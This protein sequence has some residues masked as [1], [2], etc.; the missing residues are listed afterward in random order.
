MFK[1]SSK[2]RWL[3]RRL[4]LWNGLPGC[5]QQQWTRWWH[6]GVE[7]TEYRVCKTFVFPNPGKL[8]FFSSWTIAAS[9]REPIFCWTIST[10]MRPIAKACIMSPLSFIE[11]IRRRLL[12]ISVISKLSKRRLSS[13]ALLSPNTMSPIGL[14]T[15]LENL[16]SSPSRAPVSSGRIVLSSGPFWHFSKFFIFLKFLSFLVWKMSEKKFPEKCHFLVPKIGFTQFLN[17]LRAFFKIFKIWA[18]F[19]NFWNFSLFFWK[20]SE[21]FGL[22]NGRKKTFSK[23]VILVPKIGFTQFLNNLGAFLAIFQ[24]FHFFLHSCIHARRRV[25]EVRW[26]RVLKAIMVRNRCTRE[27]LHRVGYW[28]NLWTRL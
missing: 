26:Q 6:S 5:V 27:D 4:A 16:S 9:L 21:F 10:I 8:N 19:G 23:N 22:K 1:S 13:G 14:E 15:A 28:L 11:S 17:D 7:G 18:I 25:D 3:S 20:F 2:S 24:F 12:Q